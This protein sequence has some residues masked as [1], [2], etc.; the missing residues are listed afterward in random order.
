MITDVID[1]RGDSGKRYVMVFRLEGKSKKV[2]NAI[3]KDCDV[4]LFTNF[5]LIWSKWG[6]PL[7]IG[8]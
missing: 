2:I 6:K 3:I 5:Y 1:Y 7:Y 4:N 8:I